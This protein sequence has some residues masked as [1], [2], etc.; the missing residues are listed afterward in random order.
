M[1]RC[2]LQNCAV[3]G[4]ITESQLP[5]AEKSFPGITEIYFK[6]EQK[7]K[8]FLQLVWIYEAACERNA[9]TKGAD[10]LS[11]CCGY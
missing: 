8:T 10:P 1:D 11:H 6:L 2:L 3:Q 5:L 9:Q 4:R 7:P